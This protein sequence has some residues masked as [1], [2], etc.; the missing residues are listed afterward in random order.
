MR[1]ITFG[2]CGKYEVNWVENGVF[3]ATFFEIGHVTCHMF[4]Q[5]TKVAQV[6]HFQSNPNFDYFIFWQ[7][8]SIYLP[9]FIRY[10]ITKFSDILILTSSWL[11]NISVKRKTHQGHSYGKSCFPKGG[12]L[13]QRPNP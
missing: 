1:N 4:N 5:L 13:V 7:F 9:Q 2:I 3:C 8:T 11:V 6:L 10:I 12:P